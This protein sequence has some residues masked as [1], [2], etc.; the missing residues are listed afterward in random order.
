[1]ACVISQITLV[2]GVDYDIDLENGLVRFKSTGQLGPTLEEFVTIGGCGAR[3][4]YCA[5]IPEP[6]LNI[7]CPIVLKEC[8]PCNDDPV[9]NISAED[10][11]SSRFVF[12]IDVLRPPPMGIKYEALGCARWCYSTESLEDAQ[13]CAVEQATE[14]T[15]DTWRAPPDGEFPH[16]PAQPP[17]LYGNTFQDCQS[18]C[19][20]GTTFGASIAAGRVVAESIAEAN[21]IA[22]S[23]ACQRA[24]LLRICILT[25][26]PISGA[27]MNTAYSKTLVGKGGTPW[28]VTAGVL[29]FAPSCAH[30]GDH[31]PYV[32]SIANGTLPGGLSLGAC[33]GVISGTPTGTGT[34]T[35]TVRATDM[36]GSYQQKVMSLTVA[37]I[38]TASPLPDA[39]IG[40]SY[41]QNLTVSPSPDIGTEVW[42]I[43]DGSLPPGLTLTLDGIV[44]GTP[45]GPPNTGYQFTAQVSF[46]LNGAT[47]MCSKQ[48]ELTVGSVAAWFYWE[49]DSNYIDAVHSVPIVPSLPIISFVPGIIGNGSRFPP[50]LNQNVSLDA[51]DILITYIAGESLS[52]T[53]WLKWAG[54]FD[55]NDQVVVRI[56]KSAGG[57]EIDLT[58]RF[59]LGFIFLDLDNDVISDLQ[60]TAFTPVIGDWY[61]FAVSYDGATGIA[62]LYINGVA[63]LV[64]TTPVMFFTTLTDNRISCL[65]SGAIG[66]SAMDMVVDE[67][68]WYKSTLTQGTI[69]FLYNSGAGNRPSG[70]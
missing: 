67:F 9:L 61:F 48:F 65:Q 20:D 56:A 50:S 1:M 54:A 51:N 28:V 52:F 59:S 45:T 44:E 7:L 21:R 12:N 40:Q 49:L 16:P 27:C 46:E 14:C 68:G 6:G 4:D 38:S 8:L 32:W 19:A 3:V 36:L 62:T 63:T 25:S 58:M 55:A 30:L 33:S 47:G 31:F 57:D 42:E 53:C 66:G 17:P 15:N 18:V 37:S 22:D 11:D 26:S 10:A 60:F 23:L 2:E 35:F 24:R 13:L 34:F 41:S 70:I 5:E 69:D 39:P 43:T 29:P 64:T